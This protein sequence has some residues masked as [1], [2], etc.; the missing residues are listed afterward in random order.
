MRQINKE[1]KINPAREPQK[2]GGRVGTYSE[3][4]PKERGTGEGMGER[5]KRGGQWY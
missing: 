1:Y 3:L 5:G 4:F 2:K